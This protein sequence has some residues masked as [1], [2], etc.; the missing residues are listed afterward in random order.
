MSARRKLMKVASERRGARIPSRQVRVRVI[1]IRVRV[2]VSRL[3][4]DMA[5]VAIVGSQ[6]TQ[7]LQN[8]AIWT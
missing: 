2:R 5:I 7:L 1:R 4:L 3:G 6:Y 8:V